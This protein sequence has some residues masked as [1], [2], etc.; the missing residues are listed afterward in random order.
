[1]CDVGEAG[2]PKVAEDKRVEMRAVIVCG[3]TPHLRVIVVN[4]YESP[5]SVCRSCSC[6]RNECGRWP[7]AGYTD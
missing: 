2:T 4:V 6:F 1:M 3:T 7:M 5:L